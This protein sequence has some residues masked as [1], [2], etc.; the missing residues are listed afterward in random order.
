LELTRIDPR[1]LFE[2]PTVAVAP[3]EVFGVAAVAA[4]PPHAAAAR[5]T[6]GITAALTR[7]MMGLLRVML[8]LGWGA[9]TVAAIG[10]FRITRRVV[11]SRK[12][13]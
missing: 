9:L 8:L 1:L 6:S 5:A 11:R 13:S 4:P 2:T 12:T 10:G 7:N 3:V